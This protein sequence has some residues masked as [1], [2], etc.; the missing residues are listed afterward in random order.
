MKTV[1]RYNQPPYGLHDMIFNKIEIRNDDVILHFPEGI[2]K[3]GEPYQTVKGTI[4]LESCDF[5]FCF[6]HLQ[7]PYGMLGQYTGEKLELKDF[8]DKYQW[9]DFEV[10]AEYHGYNISVYDGYFSRFNG[11]DKVVEATVEIYHWGD[12]VYNTEE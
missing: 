2:V 1:Y 9:R 4:T 10:S 7:A 6:V 5:D 11:E 3:I 8:V 12:V